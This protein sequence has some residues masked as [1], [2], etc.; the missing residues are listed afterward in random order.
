MHRIGHELKITAFQQG[1][2]PMSSKLSIAAKHCQSHS[3]LQFCL[4][5]KR[6]PRFWRWRRRFPEINCPIAAQAVLKDWA[7]VRRGIGVLLRKRLEFSYRF[8]D[9]PKDALFGLLLALP[10]L[11]V[12]LLQFAP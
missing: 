5:T 11:P 7:D 10:R 3:N 9:L 4:R 2:N 12:C 8:W 1:I 6:K